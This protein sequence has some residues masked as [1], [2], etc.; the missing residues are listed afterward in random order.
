MTFV[1]RCSC[2]EEMT[3]KGRTREK[4]VMKLKT[5][6][7]E[8]AVYEHM[9]QKHIGETVPTIEGVHAAIEQNL[10]PLS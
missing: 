7:S 5:L 4:A 1:M 2:G 8:E 9:A 10:K 3:A 6:L